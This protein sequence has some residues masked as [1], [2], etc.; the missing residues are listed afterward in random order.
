MAS[1]EIPRNQWRDLFDSFSRQHEGW[2][3]RVA[4]TGPDGTVRLEARDLPL[5]GVST[6]SPRD[7]RISI[8]VGA[9]ADDHL[10]HEIANAVRVTI[11]QT[12]SGAERGLRISSA[13]GSTTTVEFRSPMRTEEVDG[14]PSR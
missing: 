12:D 6:N 10:T 9:R 11:D 1:T 5:Q 8:M 2:I 14:M 3:V 13:D 4:V 7:D